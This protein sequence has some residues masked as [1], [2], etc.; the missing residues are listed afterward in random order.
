MANAREV[1]RESVGEA[2]LLATTGGSLEEL[3]SLA[4][5]ARTALN[6]GSAEVS[7]DE[8][9]QASLSPGA[10]KRLGVD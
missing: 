9:K 5:L 10:M 2:A 6:A 8:V 3:Q 7:D 1:L 4:L